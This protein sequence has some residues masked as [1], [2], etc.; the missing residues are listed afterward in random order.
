MS[1]TADG[2][3][4]GGTGAGPAGSSPIELGVDGLIG[5]YTGSP[6]GTLT[7]VALPIQSVRAGFHLTPQ[8]T[9]EPSFGMRRL[10]ASGDSETDYTLG[11]AGLYH[12]STNRT[13]RQVYVRPFLDVVGR[14]FSSN[15]TSNSDSYT[16]FGA[17]LGAKLPLVDRLAARL[18]A[19]FASIS[20][21][22]LGAP[23][24]RVGLVFGMSYFTR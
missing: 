9:F 6:V 3:R 16:Q 15:G 21:D 2:Q 20:D 12:F 1:G 5:F 4:R 14:R 10:S 23:D 24:A 11:L 17:G 22:N 8:I 7:Q 18:E 19:N 13:L